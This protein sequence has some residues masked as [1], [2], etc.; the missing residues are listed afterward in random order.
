MIGIEVKNTS[1]VAIHPLR[2][3]YVN[4]TVHANRN[5][6]TELKQ[7]FMLYIDRMGRPLKNMKVKL[8]DRKIS[9]RQ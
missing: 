7:S 4:I 2:E 8:S 6:A 9:I 3:L 5:P 1:S